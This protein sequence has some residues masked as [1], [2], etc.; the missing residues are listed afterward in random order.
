MR[1]YLLTI[2]LLVVMGNS[3]YAQTSEDLKAERE[4]Q[5]RLTAITLIKEGLV[6]Y[7]PTNTRKIAAIQDLIDNGDLTETNRNVL[8]E[9]LSNTI[10]ETKAQATYMQAAFKEYYDIGPVYFLPDTALVKL[11]QGERSGLVYNVNLEINPS[12]TLPNNF[13]LVRAGY[14]D[15]A[16]TAGAEGLILTDSAEKPLV[17][18]FP[19][20]V[21]FNN[22]G[23]LFN[24]ILAKEI[25][26]RKRWESVVKSL[27]QR[28]WRALDALER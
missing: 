28:F 25:A 13:V 6:V 9:R 10:V 19:S 15:P 22:L 4:E 27:N 14:L 20:A 23:Y 21:T 24:R 12:I 17:K 5:A 7:V 2:A 8:K 3:V 11:N 26:D 16:T 18:P 1:T